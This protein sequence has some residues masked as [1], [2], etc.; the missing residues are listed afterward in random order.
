MADAFVSK[1]LEDPM[2][3]CIRVSDRARLRFDPTTREFAAVSEA[4]NINTY[5]I[6]PADGLTTSV[7][8]F[9]SNCKK[10]KA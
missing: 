5:M 10:R 7:Q 4:G 8:Y 1:V 6:L 9:E 3:E 2:K